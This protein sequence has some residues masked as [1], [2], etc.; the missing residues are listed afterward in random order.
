MIKH[1]VRRALSAFRTFLLDGFGQLAM[2]P[3]SSVTPPSDQDRAG[4]G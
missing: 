4:S 1:R 2:E 3:I